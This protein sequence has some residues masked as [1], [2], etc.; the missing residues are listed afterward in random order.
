MP[1]TTVES[2]PEYV[3]KS[4]KRQW[5]HVFNSEWEKNKDKSTAERERISFSA[6]NAVAGPRSQKAYSIL[7]AKSIEE[8]AKNFADQVIAAIQKDF[9]TLPLE[10]QSALESAALS[11]IGQGMLQID[12]S[13]AAL[14]SSANTVAQ[15]YA[16]ERAAELVGMTRD[17]EGTLIPNPDAKWAIS[18]TTRERIREI[19]AEAFTADTPMAEIK[20]A[21]Q[22]ALRLEAEGGGIFSEARAAL[23]A[24]TEVSRAQVGGTFDVWEKSGVVKTIK[25][26]TA[27]DERVCDVCDGND[28]VVVEIGQPFPSG[29]ALPGAHPLCRC[30]IVVDE[31]TE[32]SA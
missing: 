19:I 13:N 23:I 21:I 6:A 16:L 1:Y 4:K 26:L 14:L 31:L 3:P 17:A 8:D 24:R 10:V 22:A 12:V 15:K 11:G 2:V 25:W 18:E 7:L 32:V 28:N 20:D 9:E 5:L 30:I 27:E 29:D